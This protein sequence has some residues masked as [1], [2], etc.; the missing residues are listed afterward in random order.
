M[1][2]GK[3]EAHARFQSAAAESETEGWLPLLM[4]THHC[5]NGSNSWGL[6]WRL[7]AALVQG[8]HSPSTPSNHTPSGADA[9]RDPAS[10]GTEGKKMKRCD[11]D[12]NNY[13]IHL[14]ESQMKQIIKVKASRQR[15]PRSN[16]LNGAPDQVKKSTPAR[17]ST[18][19]RILFLVLTQ[20]KK[21]DAFLQNHAVSWV[22]HLLQQ[23]FRSAQIF[24]KWISEKRHL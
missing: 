22:H 23:C 4:S 18:T 9:Q 20:T 24:K 15:T 5:R 21:E 3:L 13:K 19:V 12:G 8:L 14:T 2:R 16:G 10:C 17:V 11:N 7:L 6:S 1:C